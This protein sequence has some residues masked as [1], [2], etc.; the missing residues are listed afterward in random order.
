MSSKQHLKQNN[1]LINN[2]N[3]EKKILPAKCKPK[4]SPKPMHSLEMHRSLLREGN[5]KGTWKDY[6]GFCGLKKDW[7]ALH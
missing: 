6:P 1:F 5:E 7:P 3:N 2:S 4:Q